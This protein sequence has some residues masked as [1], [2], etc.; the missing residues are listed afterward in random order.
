VTKE[1]YHFF[2]LF[3]SKGEIKQENTTLKYKHFFQKKHNEKKLSF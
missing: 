2:T 1:H 3:K